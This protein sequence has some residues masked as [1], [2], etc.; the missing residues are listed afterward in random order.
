MIYLDNAATTQVLPEVVE[1]M[2]PFFT[3][4]YGN[5]GTHTSMGLKALLHV[6]R[7]RC[8]V[9]DLLH[10]EPE[11]IIFTSGGSES[12]SLVFHG[13]KDHLIKLGKTHI[14]T[15]E[16]EHESVLRATES[17]I[18]HGFYITYLRPSEDGTVSTKRIVNAILPGETG[19]VSIMYVNNETGAVSGIEEISRVCQKYDILFHADC[20]QAA[21]YHPINTSQLVSICVCKETLVKLFVA[22][23]CVGGEIL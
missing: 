18:K 5:P 6:T 14:I 10:C 16:A 8:Q 3:T 9:A 1:A 17:L 2:M 23:N 15:S 21:G 4:L 19:L 7:A 12:N 11:N 20:V 13:L 22:A